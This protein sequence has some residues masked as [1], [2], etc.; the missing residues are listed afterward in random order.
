MY[1]TLLISYA[2]IPLLSGIAFVALY[3]SRMRKPGVVAFATI[4]EGLI[5]AAAVGATLTMPV[6]MTI[7]I[8]GQP[9]APNSTLDP[10]QSRLVIGMVVLI[11]LNLVLLWLNFRVFRQHK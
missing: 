6:L 11:P 4:S 9:S 10:I 8:S 5:L 2:V 7:G 3:G 1:E